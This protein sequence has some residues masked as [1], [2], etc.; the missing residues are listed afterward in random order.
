MLSPIPALMIMNSAAVIAAN[1]QREYEA[2]QVQRRRKT[3][4]VKVKKK[5]KKVH[6]AKCNK[7]YKRKTKITRR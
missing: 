2:K 6:K 4:K 1:N 7:C 5:T 3:K